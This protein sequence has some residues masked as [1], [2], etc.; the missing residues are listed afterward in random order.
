M[1]YSKESYQEIPKKELLGGLWVTPKPLNPKTPK[2][3]IPLSP[4]PET[5]M[6]AG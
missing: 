2:T 4:K 1:V 3:P 5:L 6:K